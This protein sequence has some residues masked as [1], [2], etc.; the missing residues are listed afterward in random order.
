MGPTTTTQNTHQCKLSL[1]SRRKDR[2]ESS[3]SKNQA[4]LS[5]IPPPLQPSSRSGSRSKN[6]SKK[7]RNQRPKPVREIRSEKT[8]GKISRKSSKSDL[9]DPKLLFTCLNENYDL[10][11]LF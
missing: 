10:I 8:S 7:S 2:S 9:S 3:S 4:P 5:H 6:Q 11:I 1:N